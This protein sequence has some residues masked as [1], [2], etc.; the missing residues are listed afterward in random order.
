MWQYPF[1]DNI[2]FPWH[3][4][5]VTLLAFGNSGPD[6][7]SS[8]AALTHGS[9]QIAYG[10]ILGANFLW[11]ISHNSRWCSVC[12]FSCFMCCPIDFRLEEYYFATTSIHSR[13]IILVVCCHCD[14]YPDS[15]HQSLPLG[16]SC[17]YCC[18][19]NVCIGLCQTDCIIRYIIGVIIA[20]YLYQKSKKKRREALGTSFCDCSNQNQG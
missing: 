6:L 3:S 18:V 7:F 8:F 4:H 12:Y 16:I 9:P 17:P 2:I 10:A 19:Y 14:I 20:R 5:G 1:D 15:R 13:H 11:L